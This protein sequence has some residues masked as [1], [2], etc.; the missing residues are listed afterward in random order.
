LQHTG[1][2]GSLHPLVETDPAEQGADEFPEHFRHEVAD[3]QDDQ[4]A[5]QVR[6][7]RQKLAEGI[8]E[9]LG[10]VNR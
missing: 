2:A 9:G 7:E 3:D 4:A 10:E 5:E 8:F 6:D 1:D